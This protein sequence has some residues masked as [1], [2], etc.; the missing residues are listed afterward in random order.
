MKRKLLFLFL[1][2]AAFA[3][4]WAQ[5]SVSGKV[6][7]AEDGSALPGVNVV[8]VGSQQGSITDVDGNYSLEVPDG[9][10]LK[11]SYI[12]YKEVEIAIGN[13]SVIDIAME[14]DVTQPSE[15]VVTA[16]GVQRETKALNYSVTNVD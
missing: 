5:R 14:A 13:K 4:V 15:V 1:M 12:G 10:S 11:F 2:T 9:A 3:Q 7:S 16:L 8:V 6:T